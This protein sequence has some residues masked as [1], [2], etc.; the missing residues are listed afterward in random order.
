[1]VFRVERHSERRE[2]RD[3]GQ[4]KTEREETGKA[5]DGKQKEGERREKTRMKN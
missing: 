5:W 2:I 4:R 3:R 1:M